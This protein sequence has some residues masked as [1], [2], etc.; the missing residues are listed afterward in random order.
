MWRSVRGRVVGWS[1]LMRQPKYLIGTLAGAA[2]MTFFALR[3]TIR[4][5]RLASTRFEERLDEVALWL[6]IAEHAM[7]LVL[8]V[9]LSLWWLWPFGKATVE[10]TATELHVLMPAPLRRRHLIQ[11]AVLRSQLGIVFGSLMISFFSA[12][13]SGFGWRFVS[14]WLF[15][16]LWN[17][18]ARGRGLWIARLGELPASSAWA[19]RAL[20]VG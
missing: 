4:A 12:R 18:H 19:R 14:V 11:Y 20:V 6:P 10:L 7:A 13:G 15:L 9:G 17:L 5:N 3:P 1:R 8:L 16:N 2:W